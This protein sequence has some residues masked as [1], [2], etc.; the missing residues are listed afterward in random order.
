MFRLAAALI[1]FSVPAF[2][3]DPCM[4][5]R[6]KEN[7]SPAAMAAYVACQNAAAVARLPPGT[8]AQARPK[9]VRAKP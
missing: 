4:A 8:P 1:L 2:A 9:A 3:Y 7:E 6:A 5:L